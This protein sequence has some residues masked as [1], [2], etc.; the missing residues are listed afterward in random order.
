MCPVEIRCG[1]K[2]VGSLVVASSIDLPSPEKDGPGGSVDYEGDETG[3][4]ILHTDD[5]DTPGQLRFRDEALIKTVIVPY[6]N[7]LIP[8]AAIPIE[9]VVRR[10]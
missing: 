9:I 10:I 2:F 8:N 7:G 6:P 4:V 1:G 3:R 5:G